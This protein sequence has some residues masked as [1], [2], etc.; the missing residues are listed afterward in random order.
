MS[1]FFVNKNTS[2]NI[3]QE[4]P[5]FGDGFSTDSR[6]TIKKVVE[7]TGRVFA[8]YDKKLEKIAPSMTTLADKV[9]SQERDLKNTRTDNAKSLAVFVAFFTFVSISFSILPRISHP[10][11]LLGI[12]LA[13][14]GC[15]T[16]VI[17]LLAWILDI[18]RDKWFT[19][20]QIVVGLLAICL[21]LGGF[22]TAQLGYKDMKN[23]D[24]YT[25][26]EINELLVIQKEQLELQIQNGE[27]Y[28]N[29]ILSK[30]KVCVATRGLWSCLSE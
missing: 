7:E 1:D 11:V 5:K 8:Y 17:L 21:L 24:F 18:Q 13:L 16:F 30:F 10:F 26:E 22:F 12:L 9:N 6:L 28:T 15:L 20:K 4:P 25:Q 27:K 29:D 19:I 23:N 14:L 3:N 2:T